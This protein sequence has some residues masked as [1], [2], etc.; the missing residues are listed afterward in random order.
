[1]AKLSGQ[2]IICDS[3]SLISLTDSCFV[4]ALYFLKRRFSGKFFIPPSVEEECVSRPRRLMQ[5]AMH[6]LRLRRAIND[7][8]IEVVCSPDRKSTSEVRFL[9][10]STFFAGGTPLKLLHEGESEVLALAE[11]LS[12]N[13]ILMDERTTRMMVESPEGL[14]TLL[15]RELRREITINEENLASFLRLAK[16]FT[17]FRSSELLLLAAEKGFFADYGEL[18]AEAVEAALYKLKFAGCSVGF[19]EIEAY[20]ARKG[21]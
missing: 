15:A 2:P 1:M 6:A 9:A 13:C 12:V 5:H 10:N 21:K 19:N 14:R 18:E 7:R 4:R 16:G 17:F 11:E 3:S 20:F 8:V